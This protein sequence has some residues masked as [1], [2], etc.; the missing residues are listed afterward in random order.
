MSGHHLEKGA[1]SFF[2]VV[3]GG[4]RGQELVKH[5]PNSKCNL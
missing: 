5:P 4:F 3:T 2:V 1:H